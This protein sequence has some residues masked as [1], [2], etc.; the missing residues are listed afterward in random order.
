MILGHKKKA[1]CGQHPAFTLRTPGDG[2]KNLRAHSRSK[3]WYSGTGKKYLQPTTTTNGVNDQSYR[4]YH[5]FN[6]F[7]LSPNRIG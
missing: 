4:K 5:S 1:G 7:G 6:R 3:N 2:R